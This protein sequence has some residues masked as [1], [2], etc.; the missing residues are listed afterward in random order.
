MERGKMGIGYLR[1]EIG[2]WI[3]EIGYL[4]LGIGY[5]GLDFGQKSNRRW[6][7]PLNNPGK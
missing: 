3:L 6:A 5:W 7:N 1:L 2:Y 4:R